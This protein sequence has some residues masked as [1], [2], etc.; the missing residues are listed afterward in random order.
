MDSL[1][2]LKQKIDQLDEYKKQVE[3]LETAVNFERQSIEIWRTLF[4]K[5]YEYGQIMKKENVSY[6]TKA[7]NALAREANM[8]ETVNQYKGSQIELTTQITRL[9]ETVARL[10]D[11]NAELKIDLNNAVETGQNLKKKI[12]DLDTMITTLN[13]EK[14][15]L[16]IELN[17]ASAEVARLSTYD[18]EVLKRQAADGGNVQELLENRLRET[19][20]Q[21]QQLDERNKGLSKELANS[22]KKVEQLQAEKRVLEGM[23][24]GENYGARGIIWMRPVQARLMV[25]IGHGGQGCSSLVAG[26]AKGLADRGKTV[27]VIDCD[28][29]APK[30]HSILNV[31]PI[32]DYSIYAKLTS[33]MK[34]SLGKVLAIGLPIYEHL[35]KELIIAV[36]K[37]KNGQLD[38]LSGLVTCRST[39]EISGMD[40]N[41]LCVELASK[42]DYIIVDLGR[43]EG[44]GGIARQQ[45]AFMSHA[46]RKF[47]VT[48]NNMECVK[49]TLN[50]LIQ[51]RID[52]DTIEL[53]FD[54]IQERT[55][56]GLDN[57]IRR[58]KRT[59]E[60]PMDKGMLG[61]VMPLKQ[62]NS[63]IKQ[64][65]YS[66]LGDEH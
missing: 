2:E 47:V 50:R 12:D 6:A 48:S 3:E 52:V 26:V 33:E 44:N 20:E 65:V 39:S 22:H 24:D 25:F 10:T 32:I 19:K 38:L 21:V 55:D 66:E 31:N 7:K 29:R 43:A 15:L 18:I 46:N 58:V 34:S 17:K 16:S 60:I 59:Y 41:A 63:T 37:T 30:Q 40:F 36:D 49:S 53:V 27:V 9:T 13:D 14:K 5:I 57:L 42:Y 45:Q 35:D 64:I 11:D 51:A 61:K 8:E 62:N 23:L 28:F 1:E 4:N 54:M 56:K